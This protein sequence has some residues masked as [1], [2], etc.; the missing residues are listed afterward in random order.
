M[1]PATGTLLAPS[2]LMVG[3]GVGVGYVVVGAG[4][5]GLAAAVVLAGA[6]ESVTLLEGHG[7]VGGGTRSAELTLPG[8]V[9]DVCSAVH[10]LALASPFFRGLDMSI[11]AVEWVHPH[12][13]V[14]HPLDG[15]TAAV[16]ERSIRLT[17]ETLEEDAGRYAA[18]MRP[19]VAAWSP[20]IR[21]VLA[22]TSFPHDPLALARFGLLALLPAATL[23]RARFRGRRAR[24]LFAGIAAHSTL[25]LDRPLS[26][27]AG[28]VL[29]FA[30]HA[31]GWPFT[32]GGSQRI[33]DTL[34]ARLRRL[35]GEI[36]TGRTVRSL[37]D[38]P[39]NQ[40]V[41]MDVT[42]R[43]LL[44]IAGD[45]LPDGYRRKLER[46]RYGPGVFKVD[47]ALDGP[48]PW[49]A[50]GCALAGTVHLGG[51]LEEVAGA[52][53]EVWRGRCPARPFVIL[54]Q[55]TLFDPDRAPAGKQIAWA[56]CH[57]PNGSA[58]DMTGRIEAQV[59]RFAPGFRDRILARKGTGPAA[60]EAY[61]PNYVGGDIGGGV[62]DFGQ[63]FARP[64]SPI[65]PY[66]T[67][68]PGL[69]LCSSSTPPGG[70]VHGMCGYHAARAALSSRRPRAGRSSGSGRR[71]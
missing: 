13:P 5:N 44:A 20:I 12:A 26:S 35:G 29:A 54:A 66:A 41:L 11:P 61:D 39:P 51:T 47:W 15:D 14:A 4:P 70:G 8:F 30:G 19:L 69:F 68:V 55:P 71:G 49:T 56:Y 63:L 52:E 33:S 31:L 23:A 60:L 48:I 34:E 32:R 16:L 2:H 1:K 17:G 24:A 7:T 67:P 40:G 59:E 37:A 65:A 64:A 62:L 9:H 42:P 46:F 3:G 10:P 36:L 53:A 50:K 21:Q 57:V 22:P 43:Q 58:E 6:G 45:I 25:P 28:L 38:L 18:L 27:A